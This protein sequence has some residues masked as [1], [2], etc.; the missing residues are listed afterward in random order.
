MAIDYEMM[1]EDATKEFFLENL[2]KVF[3]EEVRSALREM[4]Y[5]KLSVMGDENWTIVTLLIQL[6]TEVEGEIYESMMAFEL[7]WVEDKWMLTS[8]NMM[9]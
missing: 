3:T 7:E 1:E 2:D 5:N 8:I 6:N 4:D 9:G